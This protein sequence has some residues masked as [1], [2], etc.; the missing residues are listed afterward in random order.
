MAIA[1]VIIPGAQVKL[2]EGAV[3]DLSIATPQNI[4]QNAPGSKMLV[5]S[6][7]LRDSVFAIGPSVTLGYSTTL[8]GAIVATIV[9]ATPLPAVAANQAVALFPA[10]G[11]A[12]AEGVP[13]Q[14]VTVVVT[15]PA[16]TSTLV[17]VDVTGYLQ[18]L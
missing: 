16:A 11:V 15:S 9:A 14:Y 5:E 1:N 4:G 8:G 13:N 17:K 2:F 7:V 12:F 3:I 6:L 18:V 10:S